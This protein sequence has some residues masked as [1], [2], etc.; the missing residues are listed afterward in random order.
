VEDLAA[1]PLDRGTFTLYDADNAQRPI[2]TGKI[3]AIKNH[4]G[5]FY[6]CTLSRKQPLSDVVSQHRS[7]S[8]CHLGNIAMRLGRSLRWDPEREE[9][10]DDGEANTRLAREQRKGFEVA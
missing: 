9:F 4:I 2:R 3:D 10:P 7:V 5:N 6:D 1:N 8:V